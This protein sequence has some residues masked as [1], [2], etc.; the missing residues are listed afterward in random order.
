MMSKHG[1]SPSHPDSVWEAQ[2]V[3]ILDIS[4]GQSTNF[5]ILSNYDLFSIISP[6]TRYGVLN[7][8]SKTSYE[9]PGKN[10]TNC[11][12][13]NG[14][15]DAKVISPQVSLGFIA[16]NGCPSHG[17]GIRFTGPPDK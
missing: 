2:V 17:R 5:V 15:S 16:I 14:G 11:I 1:V 13:C 12:I 3:F 10:L 7:D 4:N 9:V 6:F 8:F